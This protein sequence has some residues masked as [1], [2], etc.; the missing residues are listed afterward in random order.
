M[1]QNPFTCRPSLYVGVLA[2]FSGVAGFLFGYDTGNI[3]GALPYIRDELLVDYKSS[4]T[5]SLHLLPFAGTACYRHHNLQWQCMHR[6]CTTACI[7]T[8]NL[9]QRTRNSSFLG[10]ERSNVE[11]YK[12][13]RHT[14]RQFSHTILT[15]RCES[16]G[17][18]WD[19]I[20]LSL[21]YE[22]SLSGTHL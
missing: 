1:T 2:V 9:S 6:P 18:K 15:L 22:D 16:M 11:T 20:P 13:E 5:R 14:Q 12:E 19:Q 10:A 7:Q 17:S 3:S 4:S 8:C 21:N